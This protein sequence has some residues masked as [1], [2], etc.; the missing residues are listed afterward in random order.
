MPYI[1]KDDLVNFYVTFKGQLNV[2]T[3]FCLSY[4]DSLNKLP[5]SSEIEIDPSAEKTE[6][7]D[8]MGHF[9]RIRVLEESHH[10]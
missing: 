9:K 1:L 6:F 8:K 5:Y 2:P 10:R 3:Q 4:E 7:I